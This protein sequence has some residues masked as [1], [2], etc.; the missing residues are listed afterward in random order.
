MLFEYLKT[1][2]RFLADKKQDRINPED[3][4][5]YINRA[6]REVA[7]RAMCCRVLTPISG[8]IIGITPTAGGTGYTN[9]TVVISAPDFPSGA[10]PL[11]NGAQATATANVIGG[12]VTSYNVV[13]GGAGYF[14]PQ[15][16]VTD[17]TGTG[18]TAQASMSFINQLSQGQEVYPFS[19][20]NLSAF[21]GLRAV[22]MVKSVSI[23]YANFRYS[24]PVYAFSTYQAMIR[25]YALVYR[26]VP[27]FA[28][29]YGQG[30]QG[31]FYL[32]P[33][34]SQSYQLEW[35]CFCL[36]IDLLDDTT[37]EAIPDPWTDAVPYFAVALAYQQLQNLN[38]AR[39]YSQ[40]FNEQ[41]GIYGRSARPGRYTNPYGRPLV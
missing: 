9:P 21:P 22:Y 29:Q 39:A 20:V 40:M 13:F 27:F 37:V 25:Q 16:T 26:Y 14:Q 10:L 3:L 4:I 24:L 41:L 1:S 11:P 23:L 5:V 28:A 35:D 30:T 31:N 8:A 19:A 12:V 18:A 33:I 36:P 34:P 15:I 7:M 17:P 2:Q 6:R 32:F 38:F